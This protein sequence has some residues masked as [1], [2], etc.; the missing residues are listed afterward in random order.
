MS[1]HYFVYQKLIWESAIFQKKILKEKLTN[2][3]HIKGKTYKQYK[4]II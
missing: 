2:D 1:N 3:L 4:E